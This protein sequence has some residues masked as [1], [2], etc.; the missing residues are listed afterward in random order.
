MS[1]DSMVAVFQVMDNETLYMPIE[2]L[3]KSIVIWSYILS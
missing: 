3:S 2:L 1:L